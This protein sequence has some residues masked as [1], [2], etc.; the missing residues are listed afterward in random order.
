MTQDALEI[1]RHMK[2]TE[3]VRFLNHFGSTLFR[4]TSRDIILKGIDPR[5]EGLAE[6]RRLQSLSPE[7]RQMKLGPEQ[8]AVIARKMLLEMAR[9]DNLSRA[10]VKAWETYRPDELFVETIL[11]TGFIA[12]M[13]MFMST[14]EIEF[15]VKGFK[16]RKK[17]ATPELVRAVTEPFFGALK[18]S[19]GSG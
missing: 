3:A 19:I 14:T 17:A 13:L 2:D 7:T 15:Q 18:P 12:A 4:E 1:V 16:F 10:L 8:S 6:V 5:L 9:D 11:A